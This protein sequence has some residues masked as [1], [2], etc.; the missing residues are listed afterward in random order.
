MKDIFREKPTA[1]LLGSRELE[2]ANAHLEAN[3]EY[4]DTSETAISDGLSDE[5][6]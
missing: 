3:S 1:A 2:N 6:W 4:D 5:E